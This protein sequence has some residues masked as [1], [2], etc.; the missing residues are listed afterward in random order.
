MAYS[1]LPRGSLRLPV[2]GLV[3]DT[4]LCDF[5]D[6]QDWLRQRDGGWEPAN[7]K[8]A[9]SRALSL[10]YSATLE[11]AEMLFALPGVRRALM[12]YWSEALIDLHERDAKSTYARFHDYNVVAALLSQIRNRPL[13]Q[14]PSSHEEGVHNGN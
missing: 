10:W 13:Y 6:V 5:P 3:V 12:A 11:D 8:S 1:T 14:A 2:H 7:Y 4:L 9:S